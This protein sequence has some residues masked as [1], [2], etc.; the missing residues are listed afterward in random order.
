MST[1]YQAQCYVSMYPIIS[2]DTDTG[3]HVAL[4]RAFFG[5][6]IGAIW[7]DDVQ[8]FG[9][10]A[11]ILEC[12]HRGLSIHNCRHFEDANVLCASVCA[13]VIPNAD[14]SVFNESVWLMR[15]WLMREWMMRE[16]LM[17]V[18]GESG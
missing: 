1:H 15:E 14:E 6:G 16:W 5:T 18:V 8:C 10:E 17:R 2:A 4:P 7:F 3:V 13:R 11:N 12:R 9:N